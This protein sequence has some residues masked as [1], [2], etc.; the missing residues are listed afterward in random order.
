M[1][2]HSNTLAWKIPWVEEPGSLQYM[3][4]QRVGHSW[5]TSL[6]INKLKKKKTLPALGTRGG[7]AAP[8][9]LHTASALGP[10]AP[11]PS[12]LSQ[13]IH[14]NGVPKLRGGR[15]V[16][17]WGLPMAQRLPRATQWQEELMLV[18]RAAA[19]AQPGMRE[20]VE[21]KPQLRQAVSLCEASSLSSGP[22]ICAFLE[23]VGST[24]PWWLRQWRSC[25]QCRRPQLDPWVRK[26]PWR[27]AWQPTPSILA[28]RILGTE[29]PGGLQSMRSQR[30][31][32]NWVPNTFTLCRVCS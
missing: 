6:K 8:Q 20:E 11:G 19:Q 4:S 12:Q 15:V 22:M 21:S 7:A 2:T 3:G 23:Y 24:D 5:A 18:G 1:A 29:E 16:G 9:S 10:C 27:R 28:W 32:H 17:G 26:I 25:L 31:G 30:V 13:E 14:S